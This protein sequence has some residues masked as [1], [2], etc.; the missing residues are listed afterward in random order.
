MKP[1]AQMTDI[2]KIPSASID[3]SQ[4][5]LEAEFEKDLFE[6]LGL[7]P[8]NVGMSENDKIETAGV[9]SKMRQL[10]G[11]IPMQDIFDG[12]H[13][14]QKI[15]SQKVL[16]LIQL[17]YTPEKIRKMTKKEPT[18]EFFSQD[19]AKYNITIEEGILTDSQ[20][21]SQ[22]ITLSA[23][24]TMGV[25][26]PEGDSLIIKNSNLHDKK[27][28]QDLMDQ[29]AQAESQAMQQQQQMA[30]QQQAV[31][32]EA[33]QSKSQ[34]DRSLGHERE[35]KI[36]LDQAL[37][38]ERISRS[39]EEKTSG[40]LNLIKAVKELQGMDLEH[41]AMQLQMVRELEGEQNAKTEAKEAAEK[42]FTPPE[43]PQQ[44]TP[45]PTAQ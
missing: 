44:P 35:A 2:S 36:Q 40:V 26:P 45:Q 25:L 20:K 33:I 27:E 14:S 39:E 30:M 31:T 21:Q 41:L 8:E 42:P 9:L 4:F 43:S 18:P 7:S 6:I 3:P 17:N 1:E 28:L 5:Q 34:S 32:I 15:V 16:K 23:L 11:W 22:F 10:A 13:E 12:A 19:F 38:A 37:N 29:K 24:K